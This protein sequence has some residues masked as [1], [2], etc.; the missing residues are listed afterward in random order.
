MSKNIIIGSSEPFGNLILSNLQRNGLNSAADPDPS[1]HHYLPGFAA[2]GQ[3]YK[4]STIVI[5][6]SR[7]VIWGIFKS[8]TTLES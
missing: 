1:N 4:A 3:S 8:G 2:C 5:Y 7:V 6:N